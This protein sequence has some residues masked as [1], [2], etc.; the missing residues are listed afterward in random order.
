DRS[1]RLEHGQRGFLRRRFGRGQS[2]REPR[3]D[4]DAEESVRPDGF[5]ET[6]RIA[7]FVDRRSKL[8]TQLAPAATDV[9][10]GFRAVTDTHVHA[11]VDADEFD[12]EARAQLEVVPQQ[13]SV[14]VAE[15]VGRPIGGEVRL[16][17][18]AQAREL[19]EPFLVA[20]VDV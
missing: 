7:A 16:P 20:A 17:A 6:G 9:D 19:G 2:D 8:D 18:G 3:V 5:D 14:E 1:G 10:G 12:A 4:V 13:G 11:G 15:V